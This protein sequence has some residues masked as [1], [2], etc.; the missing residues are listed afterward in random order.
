MIGFFPPGQ[1]SSLAHQSVNR[2][3]VLLFRRHPSH[4]NGQ[5]RRGEIWRSL[6]AMSQSSLR[7]LADAFVQLTEAQVVGQNCC[8]TRL[9][10]GSLS[11]FG[12]RLSA[13]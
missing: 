5:S 7:I 9:I 1:G 3:V 4:P 2:T 12:K 10:A 11:I 13:P 8:F 6:K